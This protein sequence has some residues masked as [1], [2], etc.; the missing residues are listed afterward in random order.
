MRR[1]QL[2]AIGASLLV[3]LLFSTA[4][5][6]QDPSAGNPPP[7]NWGGSMHSSGWFKSMFGTDETKEETKKDPDSAPAKPAAKEPAK[8]VQPPPKP[9][10]E[11][12]RGATQRAQEQAK[13]LRRLAVC[14]QLKLIAYQ[15]KDDAL[16]HRAEQLE[17]RAQ[18]LYNQRI[19]QLPASKVAATSKGLSPSKPA[20]SSAPENAL[21][22]TSLPSLDKD[23]ATA[24]APESKS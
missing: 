20:Q 12:R 7:S 14:D 17:D 21:H 3:G 6:A 1:A 16:L 8:N 9:A 18:S 2:G 19:A 13:L 10:A 24:A 11:A 15:T 23:K 22:S 4:T 5:M